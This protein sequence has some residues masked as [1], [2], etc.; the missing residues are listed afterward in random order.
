[1]W[2][3][4]HFILFGFFIKADLFVLNGGA[5]WSNW[6]EWSDCTVTCGDG[7]SLRTR[8]CIKNFLQSSCPGVAL[9]VLPCNYKKCPKENAVCSTIKASDCSKETKDSVSNILKESAYNDLLAEVSKWSLERL[10]L[11]SECTGDIGDLDDHIDDL[12]NQVSS[13][14]NANKATS[15]VLNNIKVLVGCSE[16][17]NGQ[18]LYERCQAIVGQN[19]T[20]SS[21][22]NKLNMFLDGLENVKSQ[23]QKYGF[24]T[25]IIK[26]VLQ[27]FLKF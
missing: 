14:T 7:V 16:D 15:S 23:C 6:K 12:K 5:S 13:L 3:N 2:S 11:I 22:I 20:M 8:I 21:E 9:E 25:S 10:S 24:V 19:D 26:K 17:T 4:V 27:P 1:M 18:T